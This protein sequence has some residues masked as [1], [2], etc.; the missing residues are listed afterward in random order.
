[1]AWPLTKT[2]ASEARKSAIAAMSCGWPTRGMRWPAAERASRKAR[3][4]SASS[5]ET[6]KARAR[7]WVAMVPGQMA[8]ERM[9]KSASSTE[10]LFARWIT[11]AL[12]VL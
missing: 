9:L 7:S 12:Q 4:G 1:M 8:L 11:A 5:L 10:A 2:L 6:P 3:K